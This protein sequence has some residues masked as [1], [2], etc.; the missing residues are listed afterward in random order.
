VLKDSPYRLVFPDNGVLFPAGDIPL[1]VPTTLGKEFAE[2]IER[3]NEREGT[4]L[5]KTRW[6]AIRSHIR[7]A[8]K[9]KRASQEK[10]TSR[11]RRRLD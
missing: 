3:L 1:Q 6:K 4:R 8:A 7:E 9:K 10:V 11:R 2:R 5:P